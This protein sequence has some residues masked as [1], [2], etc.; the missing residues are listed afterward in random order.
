MNFPLKNVNINEI[1]IMLKLLRGETNLTTIAKELDIT[2]QGVRYYVNSLREKRLIED[3]KISNEGYQFLTDSFKTLKNFVIEGTNTLFSPSEWEAICDDDVQI[4]DVVFLK[5]KD[6]YLHAS[7][8][9]SSVATA[10]ASE[11]ANHGCKLKITEIKGIIA[12]EFGTVNVK[13][14]EGL[15]SENSTSKRENLIK[16]IQKA[17]FKSAKFVMGEG[18]YSLFVGNKDMCIYAPLKGAFDASNRG[19]DSEVYTTREYF[20]LN[21]DEFSQLTEKYPHIKALVTTLDI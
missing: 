11:K 19:I 16:Y 4:G 10:V 20:N 13:I 5:M 21:F 17:D 2:L 12:I 15:N 6:G 9:D 14:I 1:S 7:K 3:Y 18:A 8:R